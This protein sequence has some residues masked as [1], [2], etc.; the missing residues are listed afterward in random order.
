ME[1]SNEEVAIVVGHGLSGQELLRSWLR[2]P[3]ETKIISPIKCIS[4]RWLVFG[5][6]EHD[7]T[8]VCKRRC[9]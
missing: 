9:L 5:V 8:N 1:N 6:T 2:I 3:L 7:V 4:H